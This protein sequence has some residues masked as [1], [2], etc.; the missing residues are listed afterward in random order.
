M[1][2]E[3]YWL[4]TF[5]MYSIHNEVVARRLQSHRRLLIPLLRYVSSPLLNCL[6]DIHRELGTS[7]LS[8]AYQAIEVNSNNGEEVNSICC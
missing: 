7:K 1:C 3:V 6:A 5:H 4:P 2:A 8:N